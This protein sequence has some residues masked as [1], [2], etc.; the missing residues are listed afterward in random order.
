MQARQISRTAEYMAFFRALESV[1]RCRQ[2]LITDPF[3]TSFLRPS[4]RVAVRLSR[5][6]LLRTLIERYADRRLPG[7][8]T[9]AVARTRL[10]DEACT[11]ALRDGVHQIV[12]LGAG[13]DCRAYRLPEAACAKIFEVDHPQMLAL[14]ATCLRKFLSAIPGNVHYAAIDFNLQSL[15]QVLA[16]A[17]FDSS[18]PAMF[19]WEGV[20]NYLNQDAVDAVLRYIGN[21]SPDSRIVFTYVHRGV[22]DGSVQFEGGARIVRDVAGIGEPWTFGFDPVTLPEFLD[23][24]NL[25]IDYDAGAQEYRLQFYG[26]GSAHMR[27]YDFYHVVIAHVPGENFRR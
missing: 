20:T 25:R 21:C 3:A 2:R 23:E 15:H 4:L 5:I 9:S 1:H 26:S 12:I 8:R 11:R 14:K 6:P 16:D 10:I 13:F 24:R 7:A 18:L 27:G 19:I 22:L 17:S